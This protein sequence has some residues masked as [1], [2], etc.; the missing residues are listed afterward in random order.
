MEHHYVHH[1]LRM[2]ADEW[3]EPVVRAFA[4]IN[5]AI[6]VPMQG[7]SELGMSGSLMGWDRFDDLPRIEVPTLVIGARYDT[8]DPAHMAEMARRIPNGRYLECPNGS[9][10]A[11]YD[12]QATYMGGLIDFLR[13]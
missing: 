4:H 12:D 6:Y 8:M 9:H 11:M 13:S 2:P 3:P 5:E 1:V 10:L 7:P